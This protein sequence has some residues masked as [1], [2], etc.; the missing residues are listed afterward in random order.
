MLI[1]LMIMYGIFAEA[2]FASHPLSFFLS[3]S[4]Q[5]ERLN[6][7]TEVI[8]PR[9]TTDDYKVRKDAILGAVRDSRNSIDA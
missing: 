7:K 9:L 3:T 5:M 6:I 2:F 4:V 8:T 1:S